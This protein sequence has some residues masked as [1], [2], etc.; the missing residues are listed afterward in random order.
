VQIPHH[1]QVAISGGPIHR[2]G[3]VGCANTQ[4]ETLKFLHSIG[5]TCTTKAM[6]N[7]ASDGEL[8]ILQYL[9]NWTAKYGHLAV[10]GF[11]IKIKN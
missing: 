2:G 11:L 4:I 6:A 9:L 7:A 8:E 5:A 10:V 3:R 1:R